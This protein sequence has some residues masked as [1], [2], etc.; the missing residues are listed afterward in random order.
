MQVF[1]NIALTYRL[2]VLLRAR[3]R[4]RYFILCSFLLSSWG[5]RR[6][7]R[8]GGSQE[9]SQFFFTCLPG[10]VVVLPHRKSPTSST[11]MSVIYTR[12]SALLLR[13]KTRSSSEEEEEESQL[14]G[15][16]DDLENTSWFLDAFAPGR[17]RRAMSLIPCGVVPGARFAFELSLQ[18]CCAYI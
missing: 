16:C 4:P 6:G 8:G 15:P 11:Q 18:M 12:N 9:E 10:R 13:K 2:P 17:R 5:R 1:P 7:R 14:L 3:V